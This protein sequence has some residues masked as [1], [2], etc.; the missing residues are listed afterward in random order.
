MAEYRLFN[1]LKLAYTPLSNYDF[2]MVK[3]DPIIKEFIN[4][5]RLYIIAQR[6][7]LTFEKF[8]IDVDDPIN[9]IL[10][11]EVHQKGTP[12]ILLCEFP[13]FQEEFNVPLGSR[14]DI[15][16]N[17]IYP[18][19]EIECEQEQA[20]PFNSMANFVI[21]T[22]TE[23]Y[24][25]SPKK[26]IYHYLRE[27]LDIKIEG[28]I[29]VFLNY[30]VHY[31][32]KATEQDIIKRLTGH[33]H[34]Q[35][36]LSLEKPFHYGTLPSEEIALLFLSF[37]DNVFMNTLSI[38]DTDLSTTVKILMGETPIEDNIIYL[39]AEKALINAL[40]PKHNKL[41]YNSYP[42]SKDGLHPHNLDVYTFSISDPIT[43]QYENGEIIGCKDS[44]IIEKGRTLRIL[45]GK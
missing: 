15:A 12:A 11:F 42:K 9:P 36:I 45:K 17:Y 13:L 26:L 5:G 8:Y 43:L 34:L 10:K 6:P 7:V 27:A 2:V 22:G 39:D 30:K 24:W 19:S 29:T 33:S 32:G 21:N 38:E 3:D 44:I 16:I 18:K 23:Y 25:I 20:M 31:I 35:D 37:K 14:C 4:S 41:L 1:L 28:D 40:K